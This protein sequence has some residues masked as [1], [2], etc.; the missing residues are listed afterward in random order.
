M[1]V[2]ESDQQNSS[3]IKPKQPNLATLISS[4]SKP[5]K[6]KEDK[7]TQC[8]NESIFTKDISKTSMLKKRRKKPLK[9]SEKDTNT[10]YKCLEIFGTDFSMIVEVLSH[11]TQRQLLRKFHKEKK[12]DLER[13]NNALKRHESNLI[14]KNS[15]AQSFLEGVFKLT[16][17]SELSVGEFSDASFENEVAKK[18]KL[19]VEKESEGEEVKPLS[20]YLSQLD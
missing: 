2:E 7:D 1:D 12:R 4:K 15:R 14:R 20:Y 19:L 18:L 17:E 16:S 10:F 6:F 3:E 11:K 5:I 13:V 8:R 9:W